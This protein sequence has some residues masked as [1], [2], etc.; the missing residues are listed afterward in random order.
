MAQWRLPVE[1]VVGFKRSFQ[2]EDN[3]VETAIITGSTGLVGR[4]VAKCLLANGIDV[5]CLGRRKLEPAG[6][7]ELFGAQVP[8]L[9]TTMSDIVD[10]P[11]KIEGIRWNPG[12]EC[13]FYHF[14]W[15]GASRLT[16]G[17]FSEQLA[18]AVH[19]PNAVKTAQQLGCT[20]FVNAGTMEETYVEKHL[21]KRTTARFVSAQTN[22]SLSKI[23]CRDMCSMVA[24]LE[25]IDYV[26]TRMS[27]PL[28]IELENG[29]YVAGTLKKIALAQAYEPPVNERLFDIIS[30]VAVANAFLLIGRLGK[31]KADYFIGS[32][33][34]TTLANFFN[35]FQAMTTGVAEGRDQRISS[36]L[37][38]MFSVEEIK[39]DT[40][41]RPSCF[42]D[43][44]SRTRR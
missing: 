21:K 12:K 22:Y 37:V 16:D 13:V 17:S 40:G 34:P 5:L 10:L 28:D 38:E 15:A 39:R 24:Y 3:I 7:K 32:G 42:L 44:Y 1:K 25:K 14:A 31:N 27:V 9:S 23:A 8:Y 6:V 33:E 41:F 18:N 43:E 19:A 4:A 20:K 30:L 29:S 11:S 36:D 2:A 35:S 26:H